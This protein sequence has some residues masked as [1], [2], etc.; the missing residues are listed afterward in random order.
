[1]NKVDT[2]GVVYEQNKYIKWYR[3]TK[4]IYQVVQMNKVHILGGI[5]EQSKYIRWY[6]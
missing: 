4:Y 2:L 6:R 1:M 3:R 5:D